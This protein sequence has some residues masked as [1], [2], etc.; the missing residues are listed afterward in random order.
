[1]LDQYPDKQNQDLGAYMM[2]NIT[3]LRCFLSLF[4]MLAQDRKRVYTAWWGLCMIFNYRSYGFSKHIDKPHKAETSYV[5]LWGM[6][7]LGLDFKSRRW[8]SVRWS[9]WPMIKP[10]GVVWKTSTSFHSATLNIWA[11]L[12]T[13]IKNN[14]NSSKPRLLCLKSWL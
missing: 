7:E 2:R 13:K 12:L 9:K 10:S 6:T 14:A 11:N 1:M 4:L 8:L 5:I 3:D